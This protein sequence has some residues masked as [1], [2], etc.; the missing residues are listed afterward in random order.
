LY[1]ATFALILATA[2]CGGSDESTADGDAPDP[3]ADVGT[4]PDVDSDDDGDLDPPSDTASD[5]ELTIERLCD[6]IEPAVLAVLGDAVTTVHNDFYA[7]RADRI[8][9]CGWESNQLDRT[10][11][12]G[13][14]GASNDPNAY[15][16]E[17]DLVAVDA[18]N[19]Y[20][21]SRTDL[22]APNGWTITI[23]NMGSDQQDDPDA[24]AAIA[25]AAL[26]AIES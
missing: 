23:Q 7:D 20:S 26:A 22:G 11:R 10:I 4:T 12:V 14:N 3:P 21:M 2:A 19:Q 1:A 9:D 5:S 13:Y 8:L 6:P 24:I 16:G 17:Q 18:P 25:N 15:A